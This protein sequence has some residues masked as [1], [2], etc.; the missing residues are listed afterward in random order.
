MLWGDRLF[1][2][3][4]AMTFE[5]KENNLRAVILFKEK[6]R[7]QFSGVMYRSRADSLLKSEINRI[8]DLKDVKEEICTISG[9]WMTHLNLGDQLYWHIDSTK[10]MKPIPAANPLPSDPRYREDL[11]WL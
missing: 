8:S 10:P 5:D 1:S 4:D 2:L 7:D 6:R 3:E 11:I 9:S